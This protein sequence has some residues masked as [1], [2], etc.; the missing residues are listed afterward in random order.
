[1]RRIINMKIEIKEDDLIYLLK[2]AEDSVILDTSERGNYKEAHKTRKHIEKMIRKIN[3]VA[4]YKKWAYNDT[5]GVYL[6][7]IYLCTDK[8]DD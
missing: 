5:I 2:C 1:M 7:G 8:E 3:K 6:N 4:R